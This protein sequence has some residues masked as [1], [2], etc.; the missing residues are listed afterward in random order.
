MKKPVFPILIIALTLCITACNNGDSKH[1]SQ[2]EFERLQRERDELAVE[3]DQLRNDLE[4]DDN[5]DNS[6]IGG[7]INNPSGNIPSSS[8]HDVV[9][10]RGVSMLPTL[11]DG[12][13]VY[14]E[15]VDGFNP[16]CGDVIAFNIPSEVMNGI[17]IIKRVIAVAGETVD[18]DFDTGSV[19]VNSICLDEPYINELTHLKLDFVGP[20]IVPEG[21][22]F[23]MG[24]NRNLSV[25][26][27][28][29]SVGFIDT[30]D[31]IGKAI[32]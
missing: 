16:S 11:A 4:K 2:D 3:L 10:M 1:I 31:V 20:I 30:R 21:Y 29:A 6:S 23:V 27:R 18:I 19:F 5:S 9:I 14:I 22:I 28:D 8:S 32:T 24:D 15:I 12:D 25:D 13:E 26:S 17:P 7:G